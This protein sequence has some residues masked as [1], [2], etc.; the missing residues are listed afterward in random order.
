MREQLPDILVLDKRLEIPYYFISS[1]CFYIS[2]GVIEK[3]N[4]FLIFGLIFPIA[5]QPDRK[6]TSLFLRLRDGVTILEELDFDCTLCSAELV[7]C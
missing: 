2:Y 6:E 4:P 5:E 7:T 3:E 1:C